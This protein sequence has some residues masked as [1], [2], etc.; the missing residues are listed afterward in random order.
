MSLLIFNPLITLS[1]NRTYILLLKI[2]QV[3]FAAF[4]P[5]SVGRVRFK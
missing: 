3:F 1:Q 4:T 2:V 5:D